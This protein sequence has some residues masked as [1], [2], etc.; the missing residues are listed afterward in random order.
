MTQDKK[1]HRPVIQMRHSRHITPVC[2]RKS[3]LTRNK[4]IMQRGKVAKMIERTENALVDRSEP[5][6]ASKAR[7]DD[8]TQSSQALPLER[9]TFQIPKSRPPPFDQSTMAV[10]STTN[11]QTRNQKHKRAPRIGFRPMVTEQKNVKGVTV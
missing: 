4:G 2:E 3:G 1:I 7:L 9:H 5:S 8:N 10:A 6:Q 11:S